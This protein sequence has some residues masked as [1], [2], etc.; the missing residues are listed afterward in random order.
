MTQTPGSIAGALS[1]NWIRTGRKD[2]STILLLH[3]VGFD[4]TYWDRQIQA[5][6]SVHDVVAFDL[7]GHGL[8]PAERRTGASTTQWT[9][10]PN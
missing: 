9:R 1:L 7:P 10:L 2:A 5:L 4:L 6:Q 8:S 3:P